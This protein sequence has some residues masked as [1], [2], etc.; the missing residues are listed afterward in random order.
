MKLKE[1][2]L[3][4]LLTAIS[5]VIDVVFKSFI[6]VQTMGTPYYAI[7]IIIG[8]IFLGFKYSVIIALLGDV[9]G[10]LLGGVP[11]FPLFTVGALMWGLIPG[12]FLK[13]NKK[14][15]II[16][17]VVLI[18]HLLAT[19]F[20]SVALM[21]HYHKSFEGL[22]VDLPIRALLIIPN[23][24]VISLIIE[25]ISIPFKERINGELR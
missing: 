3:A 18:T 12:L 5:V 1:I 11:F 4:A 25:A 8:A 13:K 2:I 20:N 10:V 9:L 23:T 6:P 21:V 7:P 16:V 19:F 24:L 17:L 14:F 15:I 22:M